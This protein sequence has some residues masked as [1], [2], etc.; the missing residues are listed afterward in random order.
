M[1]LADKPLM[2]FAA[3]PSVTVRRNSQLPIE[4][5]TPLKV[6]RSESPEPIIEEPEFDKDVKLPRYIFFTPVI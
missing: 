2:D 3:Q 6:E 1:L 4:E 5:G